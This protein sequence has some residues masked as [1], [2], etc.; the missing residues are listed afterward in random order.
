MN[1]LIAPD[2]AIGALALALAILYAAW[3]EY[4]KENR[5]DAN[6]LAAVGAVSLMGSTVAWLS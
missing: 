5:R 4:Q 6:F 1:D 2:L 3:H